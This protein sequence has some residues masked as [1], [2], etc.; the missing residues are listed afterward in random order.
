MARSP[1]QIV[2][3]EPVAAERARIVAELQAAAR[4]PITICEAATGAD[5]LQ[6]F[7]AAT[8]VVDLLFLASELPDVCP[9]DLLPLLKQNGKPT[10]T[11]II[12]AG[13]GD[14]PTLPGLLA[15]G[16]HDFV[17]RHEA[18]P[19]VISHF[20][21]NAERRASWSA[22]PNGGP[23]DQTSYYHPL[24]ALPLMIWLADAT[25]ASTFFSREWLA[26]TGNSMTEEIGQ[27]WQI[28]IHREDVADCWAR[29]QQAY[30]TRQPF[31]GEYRLRRHD[32]V[33]RWLADRG[34]PRYAS[35]G[36][37][38]GYVGVA[39]DITERI[40]M[41][42]VLRQNEARQ[43]ALLA[44]M[45]DNVMRL[46]GAGNYLDVHLS[47]D[48][49]PP[50]AAA[51]MIGR[52]L[53]ALFPPEIAQRIYE[54]HQQTIQTSQI[55]MFEYARTVNDVQ[56]HLE[57]R[58]AKSSEDEVVAVIRNVTE[59]RKAEALIRYQASLLENVSDAII[60]TNMESQILSWNPAAERL[61]GYSES[62][63]LGRNFYEVLKLPN[64]ESRRARNLARLEK[65]AGRVQN[66]PIHYHRDGTPMQIQSSISY[67]L[68][69]A[70]Q[71]I[72]VVAVN[73]DV[74]QQKQAE[75]LLLRAQKHESVSLL[76]SGIAHDFNNLLTSVLGQISLAR[77]KV[78]PNDAANDHL[79]KAT[80]STERAA[81]L[82]RQLLAYTGQG[83][84]QIQ[85]LDLNKLITD[86]MGL[87]ETVLPKGARLEISLAPDLPAVEM[88]RG[89]LQQ[90]IM[91]LVINAA[92]A[93]PAS[94]GLITIATSVQEL[95]AESDQSAFHP[96]PLAPARYSCLRVRDNGIGMNE[97]I[98]GRIFDP[99]FTTKKGGSG[100]G[101]SATLGIV[102]HAGGA[103]QVASQSGSGTQFCI[104]LPA[105]PPTT[106]LLTSSLT[107][108]QARPQ[109]LVLV[110]DDEPLVREVVGDILNQAG[111]A[112]L[113]AADGYEG[114]QQFSARRS[115]IAL[116]LLDMKMPGMSG[117][118][119]FHA[120]RA[121]EPTCKI[122]LS[123]GYLD[124]D[125]TTH[126]TRQ[127]FTSFLRKPYDIDTL[128]TA[129]QR[130]LGEAHPTS[131]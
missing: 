66:E 94:G 19:Q 107:A 75:E 56:Y 39:V 64:A 49:P 31:V 13:Q 77:R 32:G 74:T 54:A 112:N 43:R 102:Q 21:H 3:V 17:V 29:Y 93:I 60:S 127:Q 41:E 27:S 5:A 95:T 46:D 68:D 108:A 76:A 45:P 91:N 2:L 97:Q 118:Q 58:V 123:S 20:L 1:L 85:P 51:D 82:T 33:Y 55:Q 110:V 92:E 26:F 99:Y 12:L 78:T 65:A 42:K 14:E 130:M 88:D 10:P 35:D 63:A 44:A 131:A 40:D 50:L 28:S 7:L 116:I 103:V 8:P 114:V 22:P 70:G 121:L 72:G 101:L 81:D 34:V 119:V 86:N 117:E 105:L 23:E 73:R 89:Q 61:Y 122:I 109:G 84:F 104:L 24:D 113:L 125:A 11:V 96:A 115:E 18:P 67:I 53:F 83:A 120:V 128:L 90:L 4:L 129:V 62:E 37:F 80:H 59:R 30:Q 87:F 69:Q 57:A 9:T 124:N 71:R 126:L 111:I 36:T 98:L 100:L 79:Q 106:A 52:N 15:A 25:M 16:A 47:G 38:L 6:L 48:P